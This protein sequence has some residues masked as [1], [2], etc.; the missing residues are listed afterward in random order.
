MHLPNVCSSSVRGNAW[1]PYATAAEM[2]RT[3][4]SWR[5]PHLGRSMEFLWFGWGGYPVIA[6]PTSMGRF[7]QYED[8][9]TVAHLQEKVDA[10]QM[11]LVC[12]DS[13]DEESWY[14]NAAPPSERGHRHAAYDAYLRN[15]LIPYVQRR[16]QRPDLGTFGCSFGAYHAANLAGRYPGIVTKAVC[17]SGLYDIHRFLDGYWDDVDYYH[18]PTAYIANM[19]ADWVQRL[20]DVD[21]VIATGEHDSLVQANQDFS[22][23]LWRKGIPNHTEI[24][25]GVFGHD[26]PFWN[27][28]ISRLL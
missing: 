26:W 20:R 12:V 3:H 4:E 23:L 16:A 7:V 25:P 2:L 28:N 14:N 19:D 13:V 1:A 22:E 18:C 8:M 15:E 24:W 10:G 11:Q 21:W 9:H 6:F 27:A 5:S 17:F